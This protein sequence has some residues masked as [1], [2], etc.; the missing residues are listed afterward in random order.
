[1]TLRAGWPVPL[2][3]IMDRTC[4]RDARTDLGR[5]K[6]MV[7]VIEQENDQRWLTPRKS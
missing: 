1:M 3:G 6:G 5:G 7:S 2:R 4:A